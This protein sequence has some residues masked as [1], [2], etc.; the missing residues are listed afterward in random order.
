[1]KRASGIL[2][3][4]TTL[5]AGCGYRSHNSA[6]TQPDKPGYTWNS[7]YRQDIGSVAV[8]T[9]TSTSFQRGV[10]F[11]LSKA[12]VNQLEASTPYKVL[13]REK[14]DTVLEGEIVNADVA[15]LSNDRTAAIPQE[16]MLT[17]TINFVWK[18]LRS[19]Q[20]L[21][22]RRGFEQSATC[23]PTLC[24]SRFTGTQQ[25]VERLANAIVQELQADW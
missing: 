22:E 25:A 8:P 16:Q 12:V 4:C 15:N 5:L 1:M 19:G 3:L 18:D 20:I 14:A 10:E 11:S 9:F 7:L 2:C 21:C 17:L 23:Y 6:T 24:E 13:P